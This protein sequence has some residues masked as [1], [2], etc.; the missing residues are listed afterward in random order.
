PRPPIGSRPPRP[1]EATRSSRCR[2]SSGVCPSRFERSS[3]I[4]RTA[5][6]SWSGSTCDRREADGAAREDA[7]GA[8]GPRRGAGVRAIPAQAVHRRADS[9]VHARRRQHPL[10]LRADVAGRLRSGS[11]QSVRDARVGRLRADHRGPDVRALLPAPAQAWGGR[12]V[13]LRARDRRPPALCHSIGLTPMSDHAM[14]DERIKK[15]QS[16]L[17]EAQETL[18]AIRQG[19]VDALVVGGPHGA[20]LFTLKTAEQPY[21]MLVEQMQE[22]AVTLTTAGDVLYC[23]RRFAE[24]LGTGTESIVG[25]PIARFV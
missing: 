18:R 6:A 1:P 11:R 21:R 12:H 20:Q 24:L 5:T 2:R 10:A 19:E 15:L 25:G 23:N 22:G 13:Q 17:E 8:P 14:D 7:R 9:A 3:A 16:E 4:S